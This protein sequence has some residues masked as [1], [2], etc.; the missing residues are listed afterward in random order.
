VSGR[1]QPGPQPARPARGRRPG[2]VKHFWLPL[3]TGRQREI[4]GARRRRALRPRARQTPRAPAPVARHAHAAMHADPPSHTHAQRIHRHGAPACA[5]CGVRRTTAPHCA[6]GAPA[7]RTAHLSP[8]CGGRRVPRPDHS[9]PP[10]TAAGPFLPPP[11]PRA[12][13]RRRRRRPRGRARR[14][15]GRVAAQRS[16]TPPARPLGARVARPAKPLH[17][18]PAAGPSSPSNARCQCS[19]V[20]SGLRGSGKG[21]WCGPGRPRVGA[22]RDD[23]AR[24]VTAAGAAG[25]APPPPQASYITGSPA[26][27]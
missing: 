19:A 23:P 10:C 13:R 22:Q 25:R 1:A 24:A 5:A 14:P 4:A 16:S 15:G 7:A 27:F 18:A 20:V 6:A 21:G 12:A 2:W 3:F 17:A 8:R 9:P 26:L 11:A